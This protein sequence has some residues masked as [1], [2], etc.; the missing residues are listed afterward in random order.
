MSRLCVLTGKDS[1][2][3]PHGQS[4]AM[5]SDL[6]S[7]LRVN[8]ASGNTAGSFGL[9]PSPT[10][11]SEKTSMLSCRNCC[12]PSSHW[13]TCVVAPLL[14]R[15]L[16]LERLHLP[17]PVTEAVCSCGATLDRKGNT[18][19]RVPQRLK[20]RATPVKR[21]V[22]RIFREAGARVRFNALVQDMNVGVP[23]A[24]ERRIE[25]LAQDLPCFGGGSAC[26]GHHPSVPLAQHRR[27]T[28]KRRKR[29][30][31]S[32]ATSSEGKTTCPEL[33][34]SGRCRLV[35]LAME[36]GGRWSEETVSVIHQLAITRAW[37]VPSYLSHQ[38]A[39]HGRDVGFACLPPHAQSH[40]SPR[41][42]TFLAL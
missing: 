9:L 19:L 13:H 25:V 41:W 1:R 2:S 8:Q 6:Q 26:C 16:L 10:R 33:V 28:P 27:A 5:A 39:L 23:S 3:D 12:S 35:V 15:V 7:T 36:T 38:V 31:A 22:A 14:F 42:W 37:E 29:Q 30:R 24:A 18:K 4:C 32:A 34:R 21:V 20:R 40:S 17:L 11:F